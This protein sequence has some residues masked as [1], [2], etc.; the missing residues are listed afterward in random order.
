MRLPSRLASRAASSIEYVPAILVSIKGAEPVIERL[1][2]GIDLGVGNRLALDPHLMA[3]PSLGIGHHLGDQIPTQPHLTRLT[4]TGASATL[5]PSWRLVHERPA[6]PLAPPP[7][8]TPSRHRPSGGGPLPC[9]S[10]WRS[11]ASLTSHGTV[12]CSS[13]PVRGP[14]TS[15]RMASSCATVRL[16]TGLQVDL[17]L[18]PVENFGAALLYG[19]SMITPAMSVLSAM[20]GL[21]LASARIYRALHAVQEFYILGLHP[22]SF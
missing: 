21:H 12:W 11:Q 19:D 15:S 8:D 20:E 5:W 17:R 4:P 6:P 3:L 1:F 2:D 7:S 14:G 9:V 10:G 16:R 13:K 22:G 18:V